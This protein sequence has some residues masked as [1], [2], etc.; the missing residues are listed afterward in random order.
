MKNNSIALN[1]SIQKYSVYFEQLAELYSDINFDEFTDLYNNIRDLTLLYSESFIEQSHWIK[2]CLQHELKYSY[3]YADS[4]KELSKLKSDVEYTYNKWNKDLNFK[5]DKLWNSKGNQNYENWHLGK[6]DLHIVQN[7]IQDEYLAKSKMLPRET[8]Y[9]NNKKHLLN[10]IE[11][12][13]VKEARR[14]SRLQWNTMKDMFVRISK[15]QWK[16]LNKVH[17]YWAD[18]NIK[19]SS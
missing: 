17:V 13:C 7:L 16:I 19:Y 5:K 14:C 2:A 4:Y 11:N 18:F 1:R 8:I 15:E 3:F 10:Y 9:V 6:D 12:Q